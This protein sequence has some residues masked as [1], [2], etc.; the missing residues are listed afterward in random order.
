MTL[1]MM[2]LR[3]RLLSHDRVLPAAVW[4]P[5]AFA[6]Q[7]KHLRGVNVLPAVRAGVVEL[8]LGEVNFAGHH[9]RIAG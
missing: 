5:F 8:E 7:P 3:P 6:I 9:R 1:S 2:Q 4:T